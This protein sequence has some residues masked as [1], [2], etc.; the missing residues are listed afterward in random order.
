MLP[1]PCPGH[2]CAK[3]R[4]KKFLYNMC[5]TLVCQCWSPRAEECLKH[6]FSSSVEMEAGKNW[7]FLVQWEVAIQI[8]FL[9][10]PPFPATQGMVREG[11]RNLLAHWESSDFLVAKR[12]MAQQ[13]RGQ[14]LRGYIISSLSRNWTALNLEQ[15]DWLIWLFSAQLKSSTFEAL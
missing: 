13:V 1:T 7:V 9:S 4:E 5:A 6:H 12:Q 14:A 3:A 2:C 15:F 8:C 10:C 11:D